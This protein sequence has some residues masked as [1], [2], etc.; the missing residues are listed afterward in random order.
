MAEFFETSKSSFELLGHR[1]WRRP[2]LGALGAVIAH[3]SLGRPEPTVVS[4]PTGSGKTAVG[5]AAP[6]LAT[7]TPARVLVLSPARHVR[8]QLAD[9]FASYEQLVQLGVLPEELRPPSV[10]EMAGRADDWSTL[11]EHDVVVALPNS[12]S[13]LHYEEDAQPPRDLFDLLIVDEAHHAPARTWSA[14]LDHFTSAPALLLTATPQRRDGKRIPGSLEYYYPL[15]L[16]LEEGFYKPIEPMLLG[17]HHD[18]AKND[19]AIATSAAELLSANEH[20]TSVALVRAG[21]IERLRELGGVYAGVG[22]DLSLLHNR[23]SK[24]TQAEIVDALRAGDGRAVGVVGM[25]GEGFDLPAIRLLCYHDKH[26]SVPAT[27]QLI[28]RL[29]RVHPRFPQSSV[30]ITVADADVYPELKGVLRDLY[31][32]DTDWA[33]VLPGIL[34]EEIAREREDRVFVRD[35]PES[36]TEVEPSHLAPLKRAFVYEV[37]ADWQPPFL[38][39]IPEELRAGAQL[40]GGQVVYAG[41]IDRARMLVVVIRYVDRPKW[42]TDPALSNVR[43]ELH[44]AIHRKPPRTDLPGVVLLNLDR[45]GIRRTLEELLS[46][47]TVSRLAGPERLGPYLD[48]LDRLSVSSV[49]IRN[50]NAATRGRASYRNFMGSGVD[51]GLRSVD[52]TRSALGHVMF[53]VSTDTGASNAGAAIEKA[54]LWLTRYGPL[55]EL[56]DWADATARQLWFPQVARQGPLLPG[57]ERGQTLNVWPSTRPLAAEL[58]PLL[59]GI[60]LELWQGGARLGAIEDLNLYVNDDPTGTL[61][62]IEAP[63]DAGLRIVGIL[64]ERDANAH[65][66]VWK[67]TIDTQGRIVADPDVEVR[68]GYATSEALSAVLEGQPPT[69]YFLDGTTT[70]GALRYDSRTPAATFDPQRLRT[71]SW[72]GVDITAETRRT[73]EERSEGK[74]SIHEYLEGYLRDRPRLGISRWIL[75]NDGSGEIAD[76]VVVEELPSGE[77]ALGL[78]HA[79]GAKGGAAAVRIGDFQEVVAQAIR[80]RGVLP[81]TAVWEQLGRRLNGDESPR[82]TLVDGSDDADRLRQKLGLADDED[83]D[84]AEPP[85]TQRLPVVRGSIGIAQPGLSAERLRQELQASPA[86]PAAVGLTQLFSV[87]SDT[88]VSDGAELQVLVSD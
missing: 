16:A 29:A 66:C 6:F 71:T 24:S 20:A 76:Y 17:A 19:L 70:I 68:R 5:L 28:G 58:S 22:I 69:I 50:T 86:T 11:A 35:L 18:K 27:A 3:W 33:V 67:A 55:R 43:Y 39:T 79:K 49:G 85:W 12:I 59:V 63:H 30:L 46:L 77:V 60:G 61:A 62:D 52:V 57:V 32:E 2:Q 84:G 9:Q 48:S 54:K 82:A 83:G 56:S 53:Q 25:L 23:L 80:S 31:D 37:P 4:I 40:L 72:A 73:A 21:S 15:R 10:Y 51:R 26:R 7:E 45:D 81:S 75:C 65:R 1:N 88:A 87:L 8:R 64:N 78:W 42:S 74:R 44:V 38:T 34:D 47:D 14:L 36:T 13:P 41:T